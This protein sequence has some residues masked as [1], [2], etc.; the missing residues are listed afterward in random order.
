VPFMSPTVYTSMQSPDLTASLLDRLRGGVITKR[1]MTGERGY[2]W[3][4]DKLQDASVPS[5]SAFDQGLLLGS[6]VFETLSAV[7][8]KI[9]AITRHWRRLCEAC[10]SIGIEAPG[11]DTMRQAFDEV[12]KAN[13]LSAARLRFTVT[14]GPAGDGSPTC[15]AS[16]VALQQVASAETV[17][18]VPWPRNERGALTGIKSTS[19]AESLRGLQFARSHG[20][21]EGLFLNTA[22]E[23]CECSSS[24]VFFAIHGELVTPALHSGCLPG[25]ARGLVLDALTA[26]GVPWVERSIA[27][28]EIVDAEEMFLTSSLRA[29]QPVTS[30]DGNRFLAAPG[31]LTSLARKAHSEF[32]ADNSDP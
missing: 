15:I 7:D 28:K 18:T 30:L 26:K 4:N 32:L 20:A 11:L 17:V 8:G 31:P 27:A 13:G 24:N 3:Q 22:G 2:V 19:Y 21:G 6:G 1:T 10:A 14:A 29:V 25:I 12:M 23:V 5:V 9:I 16:A